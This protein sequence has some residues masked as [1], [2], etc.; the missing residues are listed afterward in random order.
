[1]ESLNLC[2]N[3]IFIP[4]ERFKSSSPAHWCASSCAKGS[5]RLNKV[6]ITSSRLTVSLPSAMTDTEK[7]P[8]SYPDLTTHPFLDCIMSSG[9]GR[10]TLN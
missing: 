7:S 10:N 4:P 5:Y 9:R 2:V 1:M 8:G 3:L 6:D